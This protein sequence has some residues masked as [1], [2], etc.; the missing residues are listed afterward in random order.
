METAV[1][2]TP[3][4]P[5]ARAPR[6]LVKS[7][8]FLLKRLGWACKDRGYQA[9]EL[10]GSSPLHYGVL[11]VLDEGA[12]ET[13]ATIADALG[14]DRSALVGLL[15]DLEEH[16][17]VERRRDP[18]DRRRHLVSLTPAGEKVLAQHRA[19]A[20]QLDDEILAPLE[21]KERAELHRLLVKLAVHH[22]K[23]Y[24]EG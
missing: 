7:T 23:R 17:L 2:T 1:H 18:A 10:I 6:E 24:A 13:Q 12:R 8:A 11:A 21:P 16:G 4:K 20:G 14:F 15:D 5:D 3:L 19:I 9:F 22:D